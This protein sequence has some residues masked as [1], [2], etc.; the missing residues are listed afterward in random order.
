MIFGRKGIR[1]RSIL[2]FAPKPV[3]VVR[4][5][6]RRR[7]L[8]A[9]RRCQRQ[10]RLLHLTT[11]KQGKRLTNRVVEG[12]PELWSQRGLHVPRQ[13]LLEVLDCLGMG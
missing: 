4:S 12:E 1:S 7:A 11:S 5:R 3:R 8:R 13:E 10:A 9:L 2:S 6:L